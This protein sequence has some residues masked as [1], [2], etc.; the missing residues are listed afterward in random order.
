M[1]IENRIAD[2][3]APAAADAGLIV[4]SVTVAKADGQQRVV[5]A[6]DL[7]DDELGSASIDAI[8]AALRAIGAALDEA[9]VPATAYTLE[10]GTPGLSR[11]LT[12]RRHFL[13]AR[14]R[15]VALD[16][17]DGTIVK[18][19]LTEVDG[20]TAILDDEQRVPLETIVV[21]SIE[22]DFKDK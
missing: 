3:A 8:A 22:V 20:D 5:V 16:L 2:L 10:V 4:D 14:T 12:E 21:G 15:L 19:R 18:G 9:N 6:V 13:R 17:T 1:D 7:P 11:P